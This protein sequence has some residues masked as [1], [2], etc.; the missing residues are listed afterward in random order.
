MDWE[1]VWEGLDNDPNGEWSPETYRAL[2]T[3]KSIEGFCKWYD[4]YPPCTLFLNTRYWYH[5]NQSKR[6]TRSSEEAFGRMSPKEI[7]FTTY[8]TQ[9]PPNRMR[10][11]LKKD[12]RPLQAATTSRCRTMRRYG[13]TCATRSTR[14]SRASATGAAAG[15]GSYATTRLQSVGLGC[16]RDERCRR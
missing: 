14:S 9:T 5:F 11:E 12:R 1:V 7:N 10:Q 16:P 8:R 3:Q 13:H 15:N 4:R 2:T 6:Y